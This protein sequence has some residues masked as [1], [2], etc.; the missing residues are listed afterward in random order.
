N[1]PRV[2]SPPGLRRRLLSPPV[3][4]RPWLPKSVGV[5][6]GPAP[7][8]R[9]HRHAGTSRRFPDTQTGVVRMKRHALTTDE[10]ADF[11]AGYGTLLGVAPLR[12]GQVSRRLLMLREIV[13][14]APELRV[15]LDLLASVQERSPRVYAETVA[16]PAFGTWA[17]LA[18][19]AESDALPEQLGTF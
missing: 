2:P 17:A 6:G 14:G 1:V 13:R 18:L 15:A 3:Q 12:A 19:R 8:D 9:T 16:L 5:L 7:A 10:F 4:P 11:A